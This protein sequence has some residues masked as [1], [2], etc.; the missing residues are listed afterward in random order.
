MAI[1]PFVVAGRIDQRPRKAVEMLS[2]AGKGGIATRCAAA[3]DI[4][5][6]DGKGRI[7][8]VNPVD[9]R[10]EADI[11]LR[12]PIGHVADGNKAERLSPDA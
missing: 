11:V 4:A 8:R 9:Q 7:E 3:F 12:Q 1:G 5:D 2:D 10:I 6:M